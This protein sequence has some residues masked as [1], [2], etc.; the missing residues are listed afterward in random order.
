M[1]CTKNGGVARWVKAESGDGSLE[2]LM[3]TSVTKLQL[4]PP[5]SETEPFFYTLKSI[6]KRILNFSEV[7]KLQFS[8]ST[9]R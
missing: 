9:S 3:V 5:K 8:F 2:P 4:T 7:A 1:A 6:S